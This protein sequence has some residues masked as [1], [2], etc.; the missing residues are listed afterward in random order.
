MFRIV[1]KLEDYFILI[2]HV[3]QRKIKYRKFISFSWLFLLPSSAGMVLLRLV[4]YVILHSKSSIFSTQSEK[5]KYCNVLRGSIGS[6]SLFF[7][8]PL[9]LP[10]VMVTLVSLLF[11]NHVDTFPL[12]VPLLECPSPRSL[13]PASSLVQILHPWEMLPGHPL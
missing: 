11:L 4:I 13:E 12:I 9:S 7:Q 6:G 3:E 5:S 10:S 1:N 8:L 2:S